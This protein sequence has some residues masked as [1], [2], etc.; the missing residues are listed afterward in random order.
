MLAEQIISDEQRVPT[1]G[2]ESEKVLDLSD[3]ID[4]MRYR[5]VADLQ[6]FLEAAFAS[7]TVRIDPRR[8]QSE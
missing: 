5:A 1:E 3:S 2:M 6:S 4:D 7:E 8:A